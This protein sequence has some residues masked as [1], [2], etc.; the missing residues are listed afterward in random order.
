MLHAQNQQ[1]ILWFCFFYSQMIYV[2]ELKG[3]NRVAPLTTT[4]RDLLAKSLLLVPMTLRCSR[5]SLGSRGS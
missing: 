1:S 3:G 4:F 2:Q 5:G